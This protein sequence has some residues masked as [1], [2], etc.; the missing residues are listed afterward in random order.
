[1]ISSLFFFQKI[2]IVN[3][4]EKIRKYFKMSSAEI[5]TQTSM[6]LY[7]NILLGVW[8]V[9]ACHLD[10]LVVHKHR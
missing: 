5:F 2:G 4:Q 1:M 3:A 8:I 6:A 9:I 10:K 7:S